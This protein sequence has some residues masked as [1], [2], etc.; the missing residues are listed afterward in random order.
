MTPISHSRR[1][2][3]SLVSSTGQAAGVAV[4]ARRE[5]RASSS[6]HSCS[7][8]ATAAGAA[9]ASASKSASA[10]AS[11]SPRTTTKSAVQVPPD[12]MTG[13]QRMPCSSVRSG[14][15][16]PPCTIDRLGGARRQTSAPRP[17]STRRSLSVSQGGA[18]SVQRVSRRVTCERSARRTGST[19]SRTTSC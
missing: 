10:D 3:G 16:K 11:S 5:D 19:R 14:L 18:G 1:S 15:G 8:A 6:S 4:V 12:G 7:H 2:S 9:G 17:A 13:V